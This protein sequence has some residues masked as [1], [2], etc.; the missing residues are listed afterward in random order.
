MFF[1]SIDFEELDL[2]KKHGIRRDHSREPKMMLASSS[3]V[4]HRFNA[5]ALSI[6]EVGCDGEVGL[7]AETELRHSFVPTPDNSAHADHSHERG[8]AVNSAKDQQLATTRRD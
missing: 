8:G 1:S 4:A 7:L 6:T 2:K 3:R 5:P